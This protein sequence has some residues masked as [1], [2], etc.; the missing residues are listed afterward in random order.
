ME[1]LAVEEM[2]ARLI[3]NLYDRVGGPM[4]FRL[5]IQP[6]MAA[7]FAVHAGMAD[8]RTGQ[9]AYGWAILTDA[10]HRR[11]RLREGWRSVSKIFVMAAIIDAIYQV[12]EFRW[13]YPLETLIVAFVL[14]CVPYIL[15]RGP[16][17]RLTNA[18]QKMRRHP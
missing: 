3:G 11:E 9:P 4:S 5:L 17:G 16:V 12:I 13:V 2:L 7:F 18:R 14:A 6:A 15:I 8:G 1:R 10:A